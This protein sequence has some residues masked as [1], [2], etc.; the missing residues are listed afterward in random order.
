M[1]MREHVISIVFHLESPRTKFDEVYPAN[2]LRQ[3]A[4]NASLGSL[5]LVVDP[6]FRTSHGL[7]QQLS[8]GD[9]GQ[10][11]KYMLT[12][13]I[14]FVLNAFEVHG[15]ENSDALTLEALRKLVDKGS[16]GSFEWRVCPLC[17]PYAWQWLLLDENLSRWRFRTV[18]PKE[19][20]HP[21]LLAPRTLLKFPSQF[22]GIIT[23]SKS[24]SARGWLRLPRGLQASSDVLLSEGVLPVS[25]AQH[26]VWRQ[27]S[28]PSR[29]ANPGNSHEAHDY[30][31][32]SFISDY[33]SVRSSNAISGWSM[34]IEG[35]LV[36]EVVPQRSSADTLVTLKANGDQEVQLFVMATKIVGSPELDRLIASVPWPVHAVAVGERDFWATTQMEVPDI[37]S[38]FGK[39]QLVMFVDAYDVVLLPCKRS[40]VDEYRRFGKDI[41]VS[42]ERKCWPDAHLCAPCK[43]R[44][45]R[46]H[47]SFQAC[48]SGFPNLNAGGYMGTASSIADAFRW[49]RTH[50]GLSHG[51]DQRTWWHYYRAFPEHVALDHQQRIWSALAGLSIQGF[52]VLTPTANKDNDHVACGHVFSQYTNDLVCFLHGNGASKETILRPL[53]QKVAITCGHASMPQRPIR[54]LAGMTHPTGIYDR[55]T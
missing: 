51:S 24:R 35:R 16:A 14:V 23:S 25:L 52:Q 53:L 43:A 12:R 31:Y 7:F 49:M 13:K 46:D 3:V 41:V 55:Q 6:G 18:D 27:A 8:S 42:A 29:S 40:I 33:I 2:V 54:Q 20:N 4:V 34:S 39:D 50:G 48:K 1:G 17:R 26:F 11:V 44:Y 15:I 32:A 30:L 28:F 36:A 37:L 5:V 10:I 21:V 22:H 45:Q 9:L 38:L 19:L 47:L